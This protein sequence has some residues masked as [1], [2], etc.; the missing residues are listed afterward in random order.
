MFENFPIRVAYE[1]RP[2]KVK[3]G[4]NMRQRLGSEGS[5]GNIF[6]STRL[7]EITYK[8]GKGFVHLL[9]HVILFFYMRKNLQNF[10]YHV[11]EK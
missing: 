8:I 3:S 9:T 10:R 1:A 7:L 2:W 11:F 4:K 6:V 5:S